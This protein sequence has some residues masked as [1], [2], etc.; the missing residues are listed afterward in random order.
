MYKYELAIKGSFEVIGDAIEDL[1]KVVKLEPQGFTL[2]EQSW[3]QIPKSDNQSFT[4]DL[5]SENISP[6]N[7]TSIL[8]LKYPSLDIVLARM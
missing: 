1:H 3:S 7:F 4:A 2:G 5:L 8:K 6:E